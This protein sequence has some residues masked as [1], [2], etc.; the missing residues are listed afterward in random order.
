MVSAC[1]CTLPD[2]HALMPIDSTWGQINTSGPTVRDFTI[3]DFDAAV[4]LL[5]APYTPPIVP[6]YVQTELRECDWLRDLVEAQ[7][8]AVG[9]SNK[10]T[11]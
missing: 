11:P 8:S 10:D 5:Q 6:G 9:P 2:L 1:P 3:D 7:T 4:A